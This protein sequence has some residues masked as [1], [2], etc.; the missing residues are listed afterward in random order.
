MPDFENAISSNVK[1]KVAINRNGNI[2][3]DSQSTQSVKFFT[4]AG[5]S[6]TSNLNDSMKVFDT[7]I[8]QSLC[9]GR[10]DEY[11]A[12]RTITQKVT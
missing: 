11:S 3:D 2:A 10:F 1:V 8:G 9:G 7:F 5:I 12:I 6:A 4:I